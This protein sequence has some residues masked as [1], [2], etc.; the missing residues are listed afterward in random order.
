MRTVSHRYSLSVLSSSS[1]RC[2][3]LGKDLPP[4][5]AAPVASGRLCWIF[6]G[7]GCPIYWENVLNY[8]QT[9]AMPALPHKPDTSGG[10]GRG[11]PEAFHV[12]VMMTT[13]LKKKQDYSNQF[14]SLLIAKQKLKLR[15]KFCWWEVWG[16]FVLIQW[17][18]DRNEIHWLVRSL[19]I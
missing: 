8:V 17:P 4:V 14:T 18:F 13:F 10:R 19:F 1:P 6:S 7:W 16:Y 5:C 15:M 12:S 11:F 2:V 9:F 3:F